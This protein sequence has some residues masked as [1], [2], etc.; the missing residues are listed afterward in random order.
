M[1]A[2]TDGL[3]GMRTTGYDGRM[4]PARRVRLDDDEFDTYTTDGPEYAPADCLSPD[5]RES[6]Q[7]SDRERE[8]R[9]ADETRHLE[10][11]GEIARPGEAPEVAEAR[12]E[13]WEDGEDDPR[14]R[15]LEPMP[16]VIRAG[17]PSL[18]LN[19]DEKRVRDEFHDTGNTQAER[20]HITEDELPVIDMVF[21]GVGGAGIMA[22]EDVSAEPGTKWLREHEPRRRADGVQSE[23]E[24]AARAA[25]L[26]LAACRDAMPSSGGRPTAARQALRVKV[27]DALAPIY[28][29]GRSRVLMAEVLLCSRPTLDRLMRPNR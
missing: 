29:D 5:E 23:I 28:V 26:T 9:E 25:G 12:K 22:P 8:Y 7:A 1:T 6:L 19:A 3:G 24:D 17:K 2:T 20:H 16:P 15:D 14:T 4:A 11:I 27:R 18:T 21:G 10:D 13:R